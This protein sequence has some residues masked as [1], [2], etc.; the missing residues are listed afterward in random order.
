[1]DHE[2]LAAI[3]GGLLDRP[4]SLGDTLDVGAAVVEAHEGPVATGVTGPSPVPEPLS[5]PAST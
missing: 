2:G 5:E 3:Y 4:P 1:M